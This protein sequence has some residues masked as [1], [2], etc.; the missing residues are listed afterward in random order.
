MK[1][2]TK[3]DITYQQEQRHLE[4]DGIFL[5]AIGF[6]REHRNQV[7]HWTEH[8]L[9]FPNSEGHIRAK[10]FAEIPPLTLT[11]FGTSD[12]GVRTYASAL[13]VPSI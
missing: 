13:S 1:P 3:L 2:K 4:S 6:S 12:S 10:I 7:S 9:C 8:C 11:L 5:W